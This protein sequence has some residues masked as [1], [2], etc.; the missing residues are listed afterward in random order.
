[1]VTVASLQPLSDMRKGKILR[2]S[3]GAATG[4]EDCVQVR[5]VSASALGC[6]LGVRLNS[7]SA[8]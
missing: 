2:R 6:M 3:L 5:Q 8:K 7:I 4:R 1:M